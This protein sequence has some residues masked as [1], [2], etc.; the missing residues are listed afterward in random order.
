MLAMAD[1][2]A[3]M[4][5]GAAA[6][7]PLKVCMMFNLKADGTPGWTYATN[8]ARLRLEETQ[9]SVVQVE[10]AEMVNGAN[11]NQ[12]TLGFARDGCKII[13]GIHIT[14]RK[15]YRALVRKLERES[16]AQRPF[17]AYSPSTSS[18]GVG[19][20]ANYTLAGQEHTRAHL[21]GGV[22]M[23]RARTQVGTEFENAEYPKFVLGGEFPLAPVVD[24]V[25]TDNV[26]VCFPKLYES[27]YLSGML[28]GHMTQ[29]DV[30][31]YIISIAIP[32]TLRQVSSPQRQLS[33]EPHT[34]VTSTVI[35]THGLGMGAG[36]RNLTHRPT[37]SRWACGAPTPTPQC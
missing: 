17:R 22:W 8:V 27:R 18:K 30:I 24:G 35:L 3:S 9:G 5:L 13:I 37:R 15:A 33:G 25:S 20:R 26:G 32:Q 4:T 1:T 29:T 36:E 6:L 12:T 2:R 21:E 31:G 28:A 14:H 34:G 23:S 10:V 11:V 16:D 7:A 19:P